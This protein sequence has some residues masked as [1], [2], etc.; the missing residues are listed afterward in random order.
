MGRI[1]IVVYILG[2]DTERFGEVMI[3]LWQLEFRTLRSSVHSIIFHYVVS[4]DISLNKISLS[5]E[6][7]ECFLRKSIHIS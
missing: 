1:G 6:R 4:W 5:K 2:K 7:V 3:C